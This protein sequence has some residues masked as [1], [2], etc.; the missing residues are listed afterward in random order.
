MYFKFSIKVEVNLG[1]E[2]ERVGE[3]IGKMGPIAKYTVGP[4]L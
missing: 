2:I 3:D 4:L 1:N